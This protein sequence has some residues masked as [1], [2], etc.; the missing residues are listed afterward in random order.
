MDENIINDIKQIEDRDKVIE[1][2]EEANKAIDDEFHLVYEK[3][4]TINKEM[5]IAVLEEQIFYKN[6]ILAMITDHLVNKYEIPKID[7][8]QFQFIN[9]LLDTVKKN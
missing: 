8:E 9:K 2:F 7:I 5:A 3:L 1:L 4:K 6:C